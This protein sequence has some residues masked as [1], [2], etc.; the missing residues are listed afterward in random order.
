M[1]SLLLAISAAVVLSLGP[2]VAS[3][4]EPIR[5]GH[6]NSF[7]R[8]SAVSVPFRNG[9]NLAVDQFNAAGGVKGRKVEIIS[10]D[11][12]G[13]PADAVRAAD[14]LISRRKVDFLVGGFVS[15]VAFALTDYAKAH[16]ILYV[17]GQAASDGI[18]MA[19][20][21]RYTF[22]VRSDTYMVVKVLSQQAAK[23]GKKKWAIIAPNYEYGQAAAENFK[24]MMKELV[25]GFEVVAEQ[26]PPLGKID[27]GATIDAIQS[28]NPE[29]I[30]NVLYGADLIK[31]V[32]EGTPRGLFENRAVVSYETG[33]PE[34]LDIMK[35]DA[36][37]GWIA[38]GYP[39][40]SIKDP[41]H[42]QFVKDY[43]AKYSDY[44][45]HASVIGYVVGQM[46]T[47]ML[48][49][50]PDTNTD[51]LI[52]TLAGLNFTTPI[53][54]M[55]MRAEDHQA[56]YGTYVG[57]LDVKDGRGVLVDWSFI[58]G[59]DVMVPLSEVAKVRPKD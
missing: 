51:T 29:G 18:T 46:I 14:E 35:G 47:Q 52:K 7:N 37:K 22:R 42:E 59:A 4:Q 44:P 56:T 13:T 48:K 27:A 25:P 49:I 1:R 21:N 5:I 40:Y 10:Q 58:D 54:K 6:L 30:F 12:G 2:S 26:F 23:L 11:D 19:Q 55:T 41:A 34:W 24:T 38:N 31:L 36:P 28:A 15:P 8:F 32:R 53:G 20:G 17:C 50:A 16:K 3:A 33:L 9:L 39:W 45:R 57:K 43:Q